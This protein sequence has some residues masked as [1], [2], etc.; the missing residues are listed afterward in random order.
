MLS[1]IRKYSEPVKFSYM[2]MRPDGYVYDEGTER[3][4]EIYEQLMLIEYLTANIEF[5]LCGFDEL[6]ISIPKWTTKRQKTVINPAWEKLQGNYII[7]IIY[8][9]KSKD[10][11]LIP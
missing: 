8:L 2:L 5:N 11:L 6:N 9:T 3:Y 7:E 4:Y 10:L 1:D